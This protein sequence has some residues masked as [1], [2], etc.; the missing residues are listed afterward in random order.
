M[1]ETVKLICDWEMPAC[2]VQS[3]K[4]RTNKIKSKSDNKTNYACNE[5]RNKKIQK[6]RNLP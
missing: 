1:N 6:R 4:P 2:K 3:Y 5:H